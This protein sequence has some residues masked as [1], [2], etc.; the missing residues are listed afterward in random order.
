M[1]IAYLST[2]YPFRGGIAQFNANLYRVFE[3]EHDIRAFTFT[4]Q[5]P[6]I[7]FPGQSQYIQEGDIADK[8]E[9]YPVL[10]SFNPFNYPTAARNIRKYK[11]DML[12]MKFWMPYFAPSLGWAA[13]KQKKKGTINIAVLDNVI[14][15]EKRPGD[16]KLTK[17][18][19][20]Q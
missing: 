4:R 11:P 19:L 8:I 6:K 7:F 10:D 13:K 17:F 18:F 1:K 12:I 2:F 14:P 20:K 5:Y 9:S 3:K 16:I 15:H